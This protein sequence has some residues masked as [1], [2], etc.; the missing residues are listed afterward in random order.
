MGYGITSVASG[1][2]DIRLVHRQELEEV[3]MKAAASFFLLGKASD[4]GQ[5]LLLLS[6]YRFQ[7]E[8]WN[9]ENRD[10]STILQPGMEVNLLN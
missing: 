8:K 3:L 7:V 9:H 4:R 6:R 10:Y 5:T 1:L 2:P